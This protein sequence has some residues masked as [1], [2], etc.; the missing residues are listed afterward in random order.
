MVLYLQFILNCFK[1]RCR[2]SVTVSFV[3]VDGKA[4]NIK[5]VAGGRY[6]VFKNA[7]IQAI[8]RAKW[9]PASKN[10]VPIEYPDRIPITFDPNE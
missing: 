10:G 5:I 7:A 6:T 1:S 2:N 9:M 4:K 8:Q 3:G